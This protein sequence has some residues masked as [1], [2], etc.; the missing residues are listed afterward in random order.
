MRLFELLA[1]A[2]SVNRCRS[3]RLVPVFAVT[4]VVVAASVFAALPTPATA[5]AFG[6]AVLIAGDYI[7][8]GEAA[9]ERE[10]GTVWVFAREGE[11]WTNVSMLRSTLDLQG[12]PRTPRAG[13]GFGTSLAQSGDFVFVG[14]GGMS[15]MRSHLQDIGDPSADPAV[16]IVAFHNSGVGDMLAGHGADLMVAMDRLEDGQEVQMYRVAEDGELSETG[17]F[18]GPRPSGPV[19]TTPVALG[20]N[21]L[22]VGNPG[23]DAVQLYER[24]AEGGEWESTAVLSPPDETGSP[25][26]FGSSLAVAGNEVLVGQMRAG[27]VHRYAKVDGTWQSIGTLEPADEEMRPG[28]GSSLAADGETLLVGGARRFQ[29]YRHS[30]GSWIA[31]GTSPLYYEAEEGPAFARTTLSLAGQLAVVSDPSADFGMGAVLVYSNESG[32][33]VRSGR[34][35]A[36][37]APLPAITGGE[38]ACDDGEAADYDCDHVDLLSFLPR[39]ELG[40]ARGARLNDVWGWTD[41]ETGREYA[42]VG[43]MD[44]AS[45]VDVTDAY[46]PR[47]LGNLARTDGSPASTWRDIKVFKDHAFIVADGAGAHGMQVFDLTQLRD[48]AE[49][50]EFEATAMYTDIGS[51][52]NVAI[53]EETGYAYLVGSSGGG[54]TCGGGSHIVDINDPLNPVF[55]GCFAHANTGRS[56]TGNSHD[57]QCVIYHGPDEDYRGREICV[58]SNETALSVADVTDKDN[59]VAVAKAEYANVAYAHQGWL[60]DDHRYFYSNDELDEVSGAVEATRTLIWDLADLDDPILVKEYYSPTKVT[61]HNLYVRGD[62]LYMSNNRAGLRVLDIS[63]PENPVELGFFD[64]TPWSDD[65]SGFDGTWSVYP[66][67]ES[68]TV[69]LSSRREGLFLVKPR[70]RRL[71]P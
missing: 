33:W 16:W 6:G 67:F 26:F 71:I 70:A 9:H 37:H 38:I 48:V 27:V 52:H 18:L 29:A 22:A 25:S 23:E 12:Q 66:Y 57:T 31:A 39:E 61:D 11:E 35:V 10:P 17:S 28:W 19:R 46:N 60:T 21:L 13:D 36:E 20:S 68:G 58:N 50:V 40:A 41:P 14:T 24:P 54:E 56:N 65:E 63:D 30:E 44:G 5:Q 62:R 43:R 47:Y 42:L 64:T 1:D 59:P 55:A 51:V 4:T 7:L 34:L 53:N 69:L 2:C 15:V 49:P 32:D 45:F 3:M 8:V